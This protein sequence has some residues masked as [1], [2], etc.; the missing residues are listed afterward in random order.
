MKQMLGLI[1]VFVFLWITGN[2]NCAEIN[3]PGDAPTIQAGI[4]AA[5]NGDTVLVADGTYVENIEFGMHDITLESSGGPTA[6]IIDGSNGASEMLTTVYI[7][8]GQT[9]ATVLDGFTIR[10]GDTGTRGEA[11]GITCLDVS[12]VIQNCII[13]QNRSDNLAGI[14]ISGGEP[15]F[16]DCTISN[17]HAEDGGGGGVFCYD[18]NATFTRCIMNENTATGS[19]AGVRADQGSSVTLIDCQIQDNIGNSSSGISAGFSTVTLQ[20]CQIMNNIAVDGAGGIGISNSELKATGCTI[21]G[22]ESEENSGAIRAYSG[23][24]LMVD[25]VISDNTGDDGAALRASPAASIVMVNCKIIRNSSQAAYGRGGAFYLDEGE[26]TMFNC[27][28]TGNRAL[29]GGG[30]YVNEAS[31]V[32]I[33]CTVTDNFSKD[34]AKGGGGIFAY[35]DAHPVLSNCIVW[36]NE[37][38]NITYHPDLGAENGG[39]FTVTYSNIGH[40][41]WPGTGNLNTDPLF[42]TGPGGEYYLSH[43]GAG[44]PVTSPCVDSGANPAGET[45]YD[46][47][48]N[49]ICLD[50]LTTRTDSQPDTMTVDQGYHLSPVSVQLDFNLILKDSLLQAGDSFD[51]SFDLDNAGTETLNADIWILL[52]VY[53]NYWFYPSW[54]SSTQG[55]D[56]QSGLMVSADTL[57][58]EDVLQFTWPTGT[59][60][61]TDLQFLGAAFYTGTFSFIGD[62]E[63]IPWEYQ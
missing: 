4:D 51:L 48:L 18:T 53:G 44:Q 61:A 35:N 37:I 3:V 24:L 38:D 50:T 41:G 1:G 58:H 28:I 47:P 34:Y 32:L 10:N 11:G 60:A 5:K 17:N 59:G 57:Y 43:T 39:D 25:S 62:L 42:A 14:Y 31:P 16:L 22:N 36:G 6:C 27:L 12:P 9:N 29:A 7:R 55:M 45:C 63:I 26:F 46:L 23:F 21:S 56:F 19:G 15:Q 33:N 20:N 54:I 13:E 52:D 49:Q 2:V 8:N 30:F 40:T